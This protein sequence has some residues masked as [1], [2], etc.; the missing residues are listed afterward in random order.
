MVALILSSGNA[1]LCSMEYN[2]YMHDIC[3]GEVNARC[4]VNT[5]FKRQIEEHSIGRL[6]NTKGKQY[7]L[8][9]S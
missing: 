4:V 2:F 8:S 3:I 7:A 5:F 1:L 6:R 9:V